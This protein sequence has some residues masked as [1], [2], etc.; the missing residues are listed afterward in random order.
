MWY[1]PGTHSVIWP[2]VPFLCT[3]L[4]VSSFLWQLR[5]Q[6]ALLREAAKVLAVLGLCI[7]TSRCVEGESVSPVA[8]QERKQNLL[9]KKPQAN[10]SLCL[11]DLQ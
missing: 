9:S 10:I 7:L 5:P 11:K 2:L 1:D 6:L 4:A 8:S 3:S